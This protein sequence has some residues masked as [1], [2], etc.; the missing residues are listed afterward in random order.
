M[1]FMRV[2]VFFDLPVKSKKD[3]KAYTDFRRELLKGGFVMVQYSVYS[4]TVKNSDDAARYERFVESIV[5]PNGSVRM[6]TVT[7]KQYA[8]IRIIAGDR[9]KSENLLDTKDILEL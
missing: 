6:M 5:P 9:V 7:E 3:R 8:S 1:R 2:M 4:R